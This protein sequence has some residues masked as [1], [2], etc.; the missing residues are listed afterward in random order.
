MTGYG[1]GCVEL[2]GLKVTA[3]LRSVN[4]R[5]TD[6]RFRLPPEVASIEPELRRRVLGRVRRGRV[7]IAI[8][9]ELLDDQGAAPRASLNRN[10]TRELLQAG[11]LLEE[12][13]GLSGTLDIGAVLGTP[14][15]LKSEAATIGPDD[16]E[17]QAVHRALEEGLEA[18]DLDRQREGHRLGEQILERVSA[19]QG[20][21]RRA[22]EQAGRVPSLLRDRL[23]SRL[24]TL[25]GD[26]EL[27]PQRVAQEAA[28]L[29]ERSDVTE[30]LDRLGAHLEQ[31]ES[32]LAA[33]DGEPVGRRLD[34]LIQEIHRETNTVTSKSTDLELTREALALKLETEKVREQVQN[35]E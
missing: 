9:S 12:E 33:P 17:W 5:Y 19:M 10:L 4:N 25:A 24:E 15:I 16:A 26:V 28:L 27:D 8:K 34:F 2:P 32:L 20:L 1:Q 13:F 29:A 35:L 18:L 23:L 7:D 3:E 31:V 14:G 22:R 11:Q 21:A 30:E 6:L